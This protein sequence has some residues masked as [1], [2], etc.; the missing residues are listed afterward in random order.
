METLR[1]QISAKVHQVSGVECEVVLVAPKSL[2]FTS[3]GK[4]SRAA[5]KKGYLAGEIAEISRRYVD[6]LNPGR[7]A[8]ALAS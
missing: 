6:A 7:P 1:R 3:S 2:P 4:L 8:V 5:A